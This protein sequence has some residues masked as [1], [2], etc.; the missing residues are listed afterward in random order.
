[1]AN[2]AM[3]KPGVTAAPGG[4]ENWEECEWTGWLVEANPG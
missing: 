2:N 1:M 3:K 4:I